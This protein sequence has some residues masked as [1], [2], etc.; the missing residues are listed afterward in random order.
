MARQQRI[1]V[2][3]H[4]KTGTVLMR[5][6]FERVAKLFRLRWMN[7]SDRPIPHDEWDVAF[8]RHSQF[9]GLNPALAVRGVH[10]V[11]DPRMVVVSAAFYHQRSDEK[12]LHE[13]R[14]DFSG[15]TYQ[16]AINSL[17]TDR[18][19]FVFEMDQVAGQE[20]RAMH[21]WVN[22]R[23]NWCL[24]VK[25]EDLMVDE[26]LDTYFRMFRHL[27]FKGSQLVR[28]LA[29]AHEESVFNPRHQRS[30]HVRSRKP[31]DWRDY[32]DDELI[33]LFRSK[34]GDVGE[35]LGYGA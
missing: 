24:D 29:V 16:Q 33:A 3:T 32:Y 7:A 10:V 27:G 14:P 19:R 17:A 18:E 31:E 1:L 8:D 11:R 30:R 20:I 25:L 6:V 22:R 12:W 26:G 5:R 13:P 4:H 35:R 9:K 34:F 2:G 21:A 23:L 28:C 15:K